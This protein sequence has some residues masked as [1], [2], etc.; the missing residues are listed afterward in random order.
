MWKIIKRNKK[1]LSTYPSMDYLNNALRYLLKNPAANEDA[2]KEICCA[3]TKCEGYFH[4]DV[5]EDIIKNDIYNI[6]VY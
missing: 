1:R 2:I 4:D 3:I 6:Q 5:A